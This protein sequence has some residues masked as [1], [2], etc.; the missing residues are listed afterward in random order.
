MRSTIFRELIFHHLRKTNEEIADK[1]S[2]AN[3]YDQTR[4][5]FRLVPE[6]YNAHLD[7]IGDPSVPRAQTIQPGFIAGTKKE[8]IAHT[9]ESLWRLTY[10]ILKTSTVSEE[11][12]QT[13]IPVA[14]A[15]Q[16]TSLALGS[17]LRRQHSTTQ[18]TDCRDGVHFFYFCDILSAKTGM[19]IRTVGHDEW[20]DTVKS[21]IEDEALDHP[22]LPVLDWF[23]EN[24][25]QFIPDACNPPENPLF[26]ARD[27][28][29][30]IEKK[31]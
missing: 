30:T 4:F 22:F 15:D 26:D 16:T 10:T 20:L 29:A 31:R 1:L 8:G 18:V 6:E 5:H 23:E 13:Y 27:V 14:G 25:W 21:N 12:P 11:L 28:Y 2:V 3:G 9:E 24:Y 17:I 7:S 19:K